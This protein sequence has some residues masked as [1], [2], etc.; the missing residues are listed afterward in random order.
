[1]KTILMNIEFQYDY[2]YPN[3]RKPLPQS[4]EATQ[5]AQQVLKYFR[6]HKLP[7]S[8]IQQISTHPNADYCLPCT[9]GAEFYNLMQPQSGELII[10]KH[11]PNAFKDTG[12]LNQLHKQQI[13]HIIFCG[14]MTQLAIDASVRAARD[15]GFSCTVLHDACAAKELTFNHQLLQAIDVHHTFLAALYPTYA[16]ISS[17]NEFLQKMRDP[18]PLT[19]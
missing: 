2:Y 6:E 19:G 13:K 10:K 18:L 12:L 16:K 7:I 3:G 14:M 9:K 5:Q 4:L 8:H 17:T 1:M 15:F 11:Y